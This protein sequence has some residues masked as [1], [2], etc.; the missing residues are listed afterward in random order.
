M[1]TIEEEEQERRKHSNF[2]KGGMEQ[3]Q[4]EANE[5]HQERQRLL[6]GQQQS[7]AD[8]EIETAFQTHIEQ[9]QD[10]KGLPFEHWDGGGF[11][12][13]MREEFF[14][15][16][17]KVQQMPEISAELPN[18][19]PLYEQPEGFRLYEELREAQEA[20]INQEQAE[21][22]EITRHLDEYN[23]RQRQTESEQNYKTLTEGGD[24]SSASSR[25]QTPDEIKADKLERAR[26]RLER[27]SEEQDSGNDNREMGEKARERPR[28]WE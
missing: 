6:D 12:D 23:D 19:W 21:P 10:L 16:S 9:T 17:Q 1:Y 13:D 24:S 26:A 7:P 20:A 4:A 28:T 5:R 8:Q 25:A 11:F 3:E 15:Q 18:E 22:D 2:E 14:K 27:L